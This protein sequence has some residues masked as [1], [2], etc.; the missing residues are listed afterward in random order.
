M[1]FLAQI[2]Q[3]RLQ[4]VLPKQIH[5]AL[6][7]AL[8][9]PLEQEDNESPRQGFFLKAQAQFDYTKFEKINHPKYLGMYSQALIDDNERLTE[10]PFF[11]GLNQ[12]LLFLK[13][14]LLLLAEAK[15]IE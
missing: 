3:H 7:P 5:Q 4:T 15:E 9:V 13:K 2:L 11:P 14:D 1:H 12:F 6:S 8:R 10:K